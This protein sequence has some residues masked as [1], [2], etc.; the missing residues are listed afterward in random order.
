MCENDMTSKEVVRKF[1]DFLKSYDKFRADNGLP[2]AVDNVYEALTAMSDKHGRICR[3]VKHFERNDA[4]PNWPDALTESLVGYIIYSLMI[5]KKYKLDVANGMNNELQAAADQHGDKYKPENT[6]TITDTILE[7]LDDDITDAPVIK[8]VSLMIRDAVKDGANQIR[9]NKDSH[10]FKAEYRKD[11]ELIR[12][13]GIPSRLQSAI[14]TRIYIMAGLMGE[15]KDRYH[16][17]NIEVFIF[18]ELYDVGVKSYPTL[19]EDK[20]I[21]NM[22]IKKRG[23]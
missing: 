20:P 4:K 23:K 14:L 12:Y 5:L 15:D 10:G 2:G 11:N 3:Q 9:F 1:N 21:I 16:E 6:F 19:E 7:A 17:G 22:E 13:E 18:D 8:L